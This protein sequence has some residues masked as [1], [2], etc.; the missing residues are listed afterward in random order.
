[1][2]LLLLIF[3]Y[4]WAKEYYVIE[5]IKSIIVYQYKYADCKQ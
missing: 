5:P 1:M 3:M 2:L 4:K